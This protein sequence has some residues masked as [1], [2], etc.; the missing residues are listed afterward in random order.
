MS[1]LLKASFFA[2]LVVRGALLVLEAEIVGFLA[3]VVLDALV[4]LAF[5]AVVLALRVLLTFTANGSR[6]RAGS[7]TLT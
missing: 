3:F 6:D 7:P 4:A 5:G 1:R 2:F